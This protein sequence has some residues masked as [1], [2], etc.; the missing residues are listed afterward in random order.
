MK[1]MKQTILT[2][3]IISCMLFTACGV[4]NNEEA[5]VTLVEG[6][7][8]ELY[9]GVYDDE[10][11]KMVDSTAKE[12]KM[13]YQDGLE[14]EAEYF[15]YYWGIIEPDY[16]D[17]Y[18]DL[19]P[20]LRRSIVEL[21][22]EIYSHT[23]YEILS[24]A[25]QNDGSYAVKISVD[26]INI[27]ELALEVYESD[28]Y[29]PLNEFWTKSESLDFETITEEEYLAYL[30]EY[31]EIIIQLVKDQLPS[32]G[33]TEQKTQTLQVECVDDLWG[34][35]EDDWAVFDEYVIYYP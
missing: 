29:E 23:K 16:G 8:N 6:N 17:S 9:L 15:A 31:G 4:I 35:N 24:V 5:V 13:L 30:N 33:Y 3:L 2:L 11:L 21:Y 7:I 20:D 10:Y 34:I 32:I 14:I 18:T 22:K 27:M 19:T 12:S 26:P 1:R 25:V 28:N